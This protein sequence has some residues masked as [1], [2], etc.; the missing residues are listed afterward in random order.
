MR[1]E[2]FFI[3]HVL[4]IALVFSFIGVASAVTPDE[5]LSMLMDGN[6][7]FNQ[8]NLANLQVN[9]KPKVR[10]ALA[11]GQHPYAIILDCS[12]SR[13]SPEIIFDRGLGEI[14]VV[15]VAGN[16]VAPHELGSIE[17][18]VEHLGSV[19]LMVLGHSKCGAVNATV[20]A[21]DK[22]TC[23]VAT[24]EGNIGSLVESI[25]PAVEKSCRDGASNLLAASIDNNVD[26]VAENIEMNSSIVAEALEKGKIKLIKA[27]YD[28]EDGKVKLLQ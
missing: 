9:S 8:G 27:R 18:A 22:P 14:F 15:R 13:L 5:A 16:V 3:A 25:A 12:D 26:L 21:L 1:K 17:Y 7:N 6:K 20:G 10:E 19:L 28:L 24:V 23:T 2:I 11:A 4:I